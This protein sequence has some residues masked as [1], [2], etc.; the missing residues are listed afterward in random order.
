MLRTRIP[1]INTNRHSA[2]LSLGTPGV[3]HGVRTYLLQSPTDQIIETHSVS[4]GLDYPGVGPEH[5][6]LKDSNRAEYIVAN[7]EEALRGFRLLTQSEGIIPGTHNSIGPPDRSLIMRCSP[8][9]C[10][11]CLGHGS[12]SQNSVQGQKCCHGEWNTTTYAFLL[13]NL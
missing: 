1:G 9:V 5:S 11:C 4:A 10:A 8:G 2:T 6:W 13:F 3:L 12:S 7:D